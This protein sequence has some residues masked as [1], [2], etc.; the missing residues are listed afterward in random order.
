MTTSCYFVVYSGSTP[1]D[2]G[3]EMFY[4]VVDA[5][6]YAVAK[7]DEGYMVYIYQGKE[8]V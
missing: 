7:R 4:T 3:I 2:K 1:T 8:L 6:I 5:S